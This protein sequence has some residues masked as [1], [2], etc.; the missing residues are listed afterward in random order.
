MIANKCQLT[1]MTNQRLQLL[2]LLIICITIPGCGSGPKMHAVTGIVT[3]KG[4]PV[5]GADVILT[6]AKEADQLKPARGVT[7]ANG[8]FRVKTYFAPGD[9]RS[10]ALAGF[11]KVTLQKYPQS[12]GIADPYKPGGIVKNELPAKYASPQQTPFEKEV[13]AGSNHFPLELVD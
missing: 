11:Y 5:V 10:G 9:E 1:S 3:Y 13:V 6:A 8:N 12:T 2:A 4:A 7:D